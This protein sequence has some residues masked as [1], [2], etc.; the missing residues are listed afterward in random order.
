MWTAIDSQIRNTAKNV[1]EEACNQN[2]F[3]GCFIALSA[4][5]GVYQRVHNIITLFAGPANP[6]PLNK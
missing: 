3:W 1:Y 5:D 2:D 4:L 6:F